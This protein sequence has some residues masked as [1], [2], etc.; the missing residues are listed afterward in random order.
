MT[1]AAYRRNAARYARIQEKGDTVDLPLFD[2]K[3]ARSS[4][5]IGTEAMPKSIP[6]ATDTRNLAKTIID[7]DPAIQNTQ[8]EKVYECIRLNG[9]MTN[10]EIEKA[11]GLPVNVVSA[12]NMRL[13]E[14]G[15]ITAAFKRQCTITGFVVQSWRVKLPCD[16][17][18]RRVATNPGAVR[19]VADPTPDSPGKDTDAQS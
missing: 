15:R 18:V 3:A 9:N 13:R 11:T 16:S 10:K 12:R 19:R 8:M 4:A 14:F 2:Q 1:S 17:P 6:V 5:P 7:L